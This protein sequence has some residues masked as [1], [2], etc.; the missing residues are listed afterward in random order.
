ME[1][2][3]KKIAVVGLGGV[4]GYLGA[5]L[6]EHYP[7]VTFVARGK[8]GESIREKGLVLHSEFKGEKLVHPE[9]V[10]ESA[11]A[12]PE[13]DYIFVCVKNYSLEEVMNTLG[14][15]VGEKTMVILVMNGADTGSRAEKLLNKGQIVLAPIYVITFANPDYSITQQGMYTVV[16][17]GLE[18]ANEIQQ[19]QLGEACELL[20]SIGVEGRIAKDI[21]RQIWKKYI[22]NC[23]YNV[24]TAAYDNSI[25]QLRNDGLKAKEYEELTKEAYEVAVAK[26]VHMKEADIDWLIHR[27]YKELQDDDTSSLQRDVENHRRS[28]VDTFCGYLIREADRLGV[29]VPVTKK[30]QEL[31]FK[32]ME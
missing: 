3:D 10:V 4:G 8:R 19:K 14:N 7:H 21:N 29:S 15:A 13:Q 26:G 6:A 12:L 30:M 27:F 25:G 17:L 16:W 32:R 9:R 23:A 22:M 28:E 11:E 24:E 20:N 18:N 1:L 5:L 31:I 2:N